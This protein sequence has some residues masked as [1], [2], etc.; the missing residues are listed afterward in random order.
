ME[1]CGFRKFETPEKTLANQF[2]F[3]L[4][5]LRRAMG[6]RAL[7]HFKG[8]L[9]EAERTSSAKS[10]PWDAGPHDF[11]PPERVRSSLPPCGLLPPAVVPPSQSANSPEVFGEGLGGRDYPSPRGRT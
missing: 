11:A 7:L 5:P 1:A 8:C 2:R 9:Q 3:P 6:I 10:P 4:R